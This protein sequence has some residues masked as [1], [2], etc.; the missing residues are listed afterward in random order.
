MY[1]L[2]NEP[3]RYTRIFRQHAPDPHVARG[4]PALFL[5]QQNTGG[6]PGLAPASVE[7]RWGRLRHRSFDNSGAVAGQIS[8]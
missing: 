1:R 8:T 7:S 2:I 6:D 4:Q 5:T 3:G